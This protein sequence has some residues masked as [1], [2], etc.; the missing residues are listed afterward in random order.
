MR[1]RHS[2][3]TTFWSTS[4]STSMPPS[5]G[6]SLSFQSLLPLH[7]PSRIT[8][9]SPADATAGKA[10]TN[11]ATSETATA[12][13]ILD[14]LH[15]IPLEPTG[16]RGNRRLRGT[17]ARM[18]AAVSTAARSCGRATERLLQ[19]GEPTRRDGVRQMQGPADGPWDR[20]PQRR[21]AQ[22]SLLRRHGERQVLQIADRHHQR[23][24]DEHAGTE[25]GDP[26]IERRAERPP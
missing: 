10:R 25:D 8:S 26:C 5:S 24:P 16:L 14:L 17:Q 12:L 7:E 3:P 23:P 13:C 6:L 2:S 11:S 21:K 22:G 20:E 9:R 15:P 19:L 4:N 1:T 18:K